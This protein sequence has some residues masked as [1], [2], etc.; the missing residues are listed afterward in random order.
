MAWLRNLFFIGICGVMVSAVVGGLVIPQ[1]PPQ[2]AEIAHPLGPVE[3]ND[4]QAV[5][6]RVDLQFEQTWADAGLQPAPT[7]DDLTLIRRISLGLTGTVPSLEEIRVFESR[8]E[9]ERLSWWL[10]KTFADRR[11]GDFVAERLRRA[12]VGVENGPFLVYRGRRFLTWLSD[13]LME[14]RPYDQLTRDLI[15][16]NGLWT[17]TPAVNF[18]TATIDQDGTKRPDPVKLAGRVTR[19]FLATRIDCVQ[20]H[21]DNLGG[22][23][24]QQDFHELA[25]FFREA[26]NSFVGIRDNDKVLYE[27]QYLYA[28]ET[29]TVPSQVPFNQHL[30]SDAATE[31]ERLA[32]WVTHP[33]NRPFARAIVNRIWAITTGKP[34]VEPVDSIPLEGSFE[35]GEYPAGLEP[36][37][38]DFIAN[39]FD[40]QR[41]VRVI[42]AT[43]A[44]QRD[45]QADFAVTAEHE[46]TWAAYP[47]TRLRPEQVIGAIQQTAALKTLD[48]ESHILTQLINYGEHNE[49]LKRYG[50]AGEDEFAEQGGTIPQRLLMMNGNLVKQRTKNDL[51]RNS[52][53]RIAQLSPNNETRIEIAYL[54]TLTRRPTSEESE[55][56]VQRME[57]STL[58]RRHQVEDLVWVLLNSSEFAWNH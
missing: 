19:A 16:E 29:T 18:V 7:A 43:K 49:F 57:D 6:D 9:E 30:L 8:P 28:D 32:N 51:I 24:K 45:S 1:R 17:D 34:L 21:D 38:D 33:E 10:S 22:D 44:F 41:L 37:A 12:Y 5:A 20:C 14:N 53:T 36:L 58:A 39:G 13:Q 54:T 3:R 15:A 47:V 11:Y 56:F 40:L 50:D 31:R 25:S 48:A 26:E 55:Y 46:E 4:I 42:A 52:A 35:T 2:V 23:L 27:H